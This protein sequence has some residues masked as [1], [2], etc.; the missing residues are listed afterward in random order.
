[1]GTAETAGG[2]SQR[3][4]AARA[5]RHAERD[6]SALVVAIEFTLI[7]VM[8]GVVLFPLTE[9]GTHLVRDLRFEYW[10]YLACGLALTLY[11]WASVIDHSLTFIGWP[12][13]LGHNLLYIVVA[14]FL[15]V[16]MGFVDDP[17]GWFALSTASA[18]LATLTIAYDL[19]LVRRR[20]DG[21][22]GAATELYATVL[23][24]QRWQL[25]LSPVFVLVPLVPLVLLV[26]LPGVFLDRHWHV[27]LIGVQLLAVGGALARAVRSFTRTAEPIVGR[28]IA[29]LEPEAARL[30]GRPEGRG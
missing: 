2:A 21:A 9:K 27:A 13:D 29:E 14:V 28:A 25:R 12:I 16:Q 17:V 24:E 22:S 10:P 8:A 7:A 15:T 5:R 26:A 19:R 3:L 20:F 1:V 23:S 11:M 18:V 6:L 30:D 4:S